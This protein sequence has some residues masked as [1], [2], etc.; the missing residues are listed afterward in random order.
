MNDKIILNG[1]T[2]GHS[3]GYTPLM[4]TAPRFG[5]LHPNVEIHWRKRTLQEFADRAI[6]PLRYF[7]LC[8]HVINLKTE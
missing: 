7:R 3:R 2:W 5:E 6:K 8:L 1:I 4:A